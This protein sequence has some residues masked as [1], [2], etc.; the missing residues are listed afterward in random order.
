MVI[1]A[2]EVCGFDFDSCL[3]GAAEQRAFV[4]LGE[5]EPVRDAPRRYLKRLSDLMFV[6]ARVLNR[7]R[8]DGGGGVM[9][10]QWKSEPLRHF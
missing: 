5:H 6:S 3:F 8:A 9:D 7:H 1:T 2:G 10:V 4:V